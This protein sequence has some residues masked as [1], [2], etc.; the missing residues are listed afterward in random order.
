MSTGTRTHCTIRRSRTDDAALLPEIERSAGE[1]FRAID[2]LAWLADGEDHP[3]ST[4]LSHIEAQ[5]SWVVVDPDDVPFGFLIGDVNGDAFHIV[6]FSV[7]IDRQRSGC[8]AALL[9]HVI[10]W[11]RATGLHAVT[12]TTF[13]DVAWNAP[14]YQRFGF[15]EIAW[16][17]LEVR[18]SGA[19]ARET[20]LGLPRELRCAMQLDLA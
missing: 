4:H 11:V 9:S 8:G 13:R 10:D 20:A 16:S 7:R 18:S 1:A 15:R 17:Q 14:F 12:L 5:T 3:L 19:L 6:E 2:S